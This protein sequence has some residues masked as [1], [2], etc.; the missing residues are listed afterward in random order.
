M[1]VC[2]CVSSDSWYAIDIKMVT[3]GLYKIRQ[4]LN[5]GIKVQQFF[6]EIENQDSLNFIVKGKKFELIN[7]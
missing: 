1:K 6:I 3:E 5:K 2:Y 4:L 7:Y